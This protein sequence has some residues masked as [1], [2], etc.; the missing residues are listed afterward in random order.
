MKMKKFIAMMATVAMV[1]GLAVGCGGGSDAEGGE[2]GASG[3]FDSSMDITIVSREDGSGT[4]G[5]FIELFGIEEEQE[6]GEK[7]DMTTEAAQITNSTSVMLTTVAGDEYAIGY[8]SLGSLDDSVKAVK[9]DGAE[10]TA[11][12]VKSG[13]YKVS[14]PFNIATKSDLNNPT[15]DD[16]IAFIMSEEGQAVVAEEGYIPLDGVEAYAGDAPAGKV[17]VG[18][19]SSVSPVMEKLIEAYAEVNPEAEIELQTTDS[20]TG[21]ENA[22]A[23]SYDIGM[24][25]R[26]VKDEELAEGLEAQ[27]IATD[28]IAVVVNNANP[29]EDLTSDQVKA[30]YTGEALTWDEVTE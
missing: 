28:G 7:V 20:T 14:R 1:A 22:I 21:M 25:S 15:A 3:E 9:I 17:V 24:A 2:G 4:R 10:A 29:T 23:G 6:D 18:G 12:N 16:F 27:V 13:D 30:I 11:D 8:V 5:A 19:S 26:E